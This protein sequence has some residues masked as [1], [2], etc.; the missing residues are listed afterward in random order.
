MPSGT[1]HSSVM[2]NLS[3][4]GSWLPYVVKRSENEMAYNANEDDSMSCGIH[5]INNIGV[6]IIIH[7][8]VDDE[9]C[10]RLA[11]CKVK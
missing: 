2:L 4:L 9:V 7:P 8:P 10:T 6:S 5:N 1:G 3:S 11:V